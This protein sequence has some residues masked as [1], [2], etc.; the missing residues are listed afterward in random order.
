MRT[1]G[2]HHEAIGGRLRGEAED[3]EPIDAP[4]DAARLA[5]FVLE[6]V[7]RLRDHPRY[8]FATHCHPDKDGHVIKQAL[9]ASGLG[10]IGRSHVSCSSH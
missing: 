9:Q 5:P 4:D 2:R 8:R 7:V 6:V 10:G 3:T 1:G